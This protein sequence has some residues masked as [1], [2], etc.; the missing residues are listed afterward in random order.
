MVPSNLISV[1]LVA[2][3]KYPLKV[4]VGLK[5]ML[6]PLVLQAVLLVPLVPPVLKAFQVLGVL[7]GLVA[8]VP[9]GLLALKAMMDMLVL[10]GLKVQ[11]ALLGLKVLRVP[12]GLKV[13]RVPLVPLEPSVLPALLQF[14]NASTSTF[15]QLSLKVFVHMDLL[16]LL[17]LPIIMPSPSSLIQLELVPV[18]AILPSILMGSLQL[19][20]MK[21]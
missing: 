11:L 8:L 16:V 19:I 18:M 7:L 3:L 13:L 9:P 21:H 20:M 15:T 5:V 14:L 1:Q 2:H 10:L 12:L 17:V 4:F 6:V